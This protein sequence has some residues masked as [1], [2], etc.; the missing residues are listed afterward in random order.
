MQSQFGQKWPKS[1]IRRRPF[2]PNTNDSITHEYFAHTATAG[3]RGRRSSTTDPDG[4]TTSF[5]YDSQGRLFET[6]EPMPVGESTTRVTK[7]EYSAANLSGIGHALIT[8]TKLNNIEVSQDVRAG[9]GYASR[10]I[11]N[12]SRVTTTIRSVP[13]DANAHTWHETT[14]HPDGTITRNYIVGGRLAATTRWENGSTP[15]ASAPADITAVATAGF[16]EGQAYSYDALGR[17]LTS[18]NSRTKTTQL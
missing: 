6:I 2:T 16:I 14:T 5:T 9:H 7:R 8:T 3:S 17:L 13:A 11:E 18:T 10:A 15:D 4:V 12:Q 1:T